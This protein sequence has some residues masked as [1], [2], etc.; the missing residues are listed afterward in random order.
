VHYIPCNRMSKCNG[1][2]AHVAS[3]TKLTHVA[4]SAVELVHVVASGSSI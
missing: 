1:V 3:A 4:T 2:S